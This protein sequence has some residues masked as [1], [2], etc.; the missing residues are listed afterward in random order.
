MQGVCEKLVG[1]WK[2]AHSR[3]AGAAGLRLL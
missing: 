1:V 3:D 2:V